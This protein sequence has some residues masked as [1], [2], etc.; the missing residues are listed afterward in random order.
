MTTNHAIINVTNILKI[1]L[2]KKKL[3][4]DIIFSKKIF[5]YIKLLKQ[6]KLIN[7]FFFITKDKWV[8]VRAY[9]LFKSNKFNLNL[10][11]V[12]STP[13][14]KFYVSLL[15]LKLLSKRTGISNYLI[16][17]SYGIKTHQNA[18]LSHR[19]GMLVSLNSY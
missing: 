10:F 2:K 5:Y 16:S 6:L 19:A 3:Y 9:V 4:F 15:G 11:K 13:S 8:F 12:F 7:S 17:T 14:K 1:T 18:I